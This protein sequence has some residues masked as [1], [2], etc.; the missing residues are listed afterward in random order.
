MGKLKIEAPCKVSE[1]GL[2][3]RD[4]RDHCFQ[5]DRHLVPETGLCPKGCD[6]KSKAKAEFLSA[7]AGLT[8][9]KVARIIN[10]RCQGHDVGGLSK[11]Q[12]CEAMHSWTTPDMILSVLTDLRSAQ[13]R[14]P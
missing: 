1:R 8:I 4:G 2:P 14:K 9:S 3:C 12:I 5:C 11:S 13:R 10:F 7:S 6:N